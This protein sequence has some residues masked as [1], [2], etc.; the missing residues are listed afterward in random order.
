[1]LFPTAINLMVMQLITELWWW[2][3]GYA[4]GG[5]GGAGTVG[6]TTGGPGLAGPNPTTIPEGHPNIQM[7]VV[8]ELVICCWSTIPE[9]KHYV[10]R[11]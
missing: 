7:V 5:G 6:Q 4:G 10:S 3:G 11:R 1:M 2:C 9:S 8:V